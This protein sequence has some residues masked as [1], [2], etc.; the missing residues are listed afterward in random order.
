MDTL[1][2]VILG[3]TFRD[4]VK[5]AVQEA[6]AEANALELPKAYGPDFSQ[7]QSAIAF[8]REQNISGRDQIV[9][10]NPTNRR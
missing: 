9:P 3:N 7:E 2:N 1:E 10:V 8:A 4:A 6:V 5:Q